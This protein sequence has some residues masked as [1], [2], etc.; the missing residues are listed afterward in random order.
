M[1]SNY[2]MLLQGWWSYCRANQYFRRVGCD[3]M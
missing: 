2:S 1:E 3:A